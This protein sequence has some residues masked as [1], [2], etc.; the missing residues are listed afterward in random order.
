M[1]KRYLNIKYKKNGRDFDYCDCYGICYL[2]NKHELEIDLPIYLDDP[3]ENQEQIDALFNKKKSDFKK[4]KLGKECEGDIISFNIKG[5][6]THV[7]VVLQKGLM[8][9]IISGETAKIESYTTNKWIN[10]IDSLWRYEI[11]L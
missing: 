1:F 10:R 9:H 4:V 11:T 6:P 8:L 2:F 3:V 5:L 7:G